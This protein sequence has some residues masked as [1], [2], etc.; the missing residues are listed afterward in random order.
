MVDYDTND[1]MQTGWLWFWLGIMRAENSF[2]LLIL[3]DFCFCI[4]HIWFWFDFQFWKT[5]S[6]LCGGRKASFV[7]EFGSVGITSQERYV[8]LTITVAKYSWWSTAWMIEWLYIIQEGMTG[9]LSNYSVHTRSI[10]IPFIGFDWWGLQLEVWDDAK[11]FVIC[12][13]ATKVIILTKT[14]ISEASNICDWRWFR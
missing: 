8:T 7:W 2:S 1:G 11:D 9:S 14:A 5:I 12:W 4:L 10:P 13:F 3:F 6:F